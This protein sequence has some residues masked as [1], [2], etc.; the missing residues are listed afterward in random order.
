LI[1]LNIWL[2]KSNYY[3]RVVEKCTE[4]AEKKNAGRYGREDG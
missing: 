2:V 4:K 3:K 1:Y